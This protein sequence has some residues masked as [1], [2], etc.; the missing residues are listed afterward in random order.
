MKV[1]RLDKVVAQVQ[2][3]FVIKNKEYTVLGVRMKVNKEHFYI[4]TEQKC[5]K[6]LPGTWFTPRF[7][8]ERIEEEKLIERLEDR[9]F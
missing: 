7:T 4:A 9:G 2:N 6:Y 3:Q 8:I 5:R 1:K